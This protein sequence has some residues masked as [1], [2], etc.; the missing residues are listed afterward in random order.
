M[1]WWAPGGG[2][3][4]TYPPDASL[5]VPLGYNLLAEGSRDFFLEKME[6]DHQSVI[7]EGFSDVLGQVPTAP[8]NLF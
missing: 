5:G 2:I 3:A 6:S 7:G 1:F 4:A 8:M